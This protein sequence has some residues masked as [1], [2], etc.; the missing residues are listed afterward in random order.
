[1]EISVILLDPIQI[2]VKVTNVLEKIGVH[3]LIG[4][5]LAS[6]LHGMVRTTQDADIVRYRS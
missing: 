5:S 2:T 4:G 3:Y 6:T 1:M